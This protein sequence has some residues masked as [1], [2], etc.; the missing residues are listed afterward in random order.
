MFRAAEA[1]VLRTSHSK[2]QT[3]PLYRPVLQ[4]CLRVKGTQG[5]SVVALRVGF[6]GLAFRDL[7]V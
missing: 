6:R 7:E 4:S 5:S 3:M 1:W 2:Q